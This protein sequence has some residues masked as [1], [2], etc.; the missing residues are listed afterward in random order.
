MQEDLTCPPAT[1]RIDLRQRKGRVWKAHV[2]FIEFRKNISPSYNRLD[3]VHKYS[4]RSFPVPSPVPASTHE[5]PSTWIHH[6]GV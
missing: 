3:I 2:E 5:E 6:F 4:F 1:P